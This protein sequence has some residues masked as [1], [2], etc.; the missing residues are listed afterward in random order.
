MDARKTYLVPEC[1]KQQETTRSSISLVSCLTDQGTEAS[2]ILR[3]FTQNR[4]SKKGWR[5]QDFLPGALSATRYMVC[6]GAAMDNH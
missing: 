5:P 3:R 2:E 6:L 1:E 4:S